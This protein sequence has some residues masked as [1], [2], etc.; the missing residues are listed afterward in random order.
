MPLVLDNEQHVNVARGIRIGAHR[1]YV[2]GAHRDPKATLSLSIRLQNTECKYTLYRCD[3]LEKFARTTEIKTDIG[4]RREGLTFR[5]HVMLIA[6][7]VISLWGR[8]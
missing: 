3:A 8:N 2:Q 5:S 1:N 4:H 7:L 6:W